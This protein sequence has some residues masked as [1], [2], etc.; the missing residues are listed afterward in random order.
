MG[1]DLTLP[2]LDG[3]TLFREATIP[4]AIV[5]GFLG[6]GKTTLI[7]HLLETRA[8]E[9][10]LVIVSEFGEIGLDHLIV[11]EVT[12]DVVLLEGGCLCCGQSGD[13]ARVLG[14]MLQR[15]ELGTVP[16]FARVIIET[17]GLADPLPILQTFLTDPL[18]LSLYRPAAI[19]TVI[20]G[21]LGAETL[22]AHANARQQLALADVVLVTKLDLPGTDFAAS[23]GSVRAHSSAPIYRTDTSW[24]IA[25]LFS[26]APENIAL[27]ETHNHPTHVTS[28]S[29]WIENDLD[30]RKV[31]AWIAQAKD[32]YANRLLRVKAMLPIAGEPQPIILQMARHLASHERLSN[33]P[34]NLRRGFVTLIASEISDDALD[35]L[36][37][38]LCNG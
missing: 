27:A 18:R 30:P 34:G 24:P 5:T 28:R 22:K 14:E 9:D 20:D 26:S 11:G 32:L 3:L 16:A 1:R 21:A 2:T 10:T 38:D 19:A 33:W 25:E 35:H 6:S 13:L 4:V 29:H 37:L 17:S 36:L 7:R 31:D 8:L 15:R 23:Q 12:E